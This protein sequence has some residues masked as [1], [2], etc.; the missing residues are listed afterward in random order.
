MGLRDAGHYTLA[1]MLQFLGDQDHSSLDFEDKRRPA[2]RNYIGARPIVAKT[3][4]ALLVLGLLLTF[5]HID[6]AVAQQQLSPPGQGP[7]QVVPQT[8]GYQAP[9]P[10]QVTP[11]TSLPTRMYPQYQVTPQ[12]SQPTQQKGN[13]Q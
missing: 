12:T 7:V 8:P 9:K 3:E 5:G 2:L 10:Y 1:V 4:A 6:R 11:Q 13:A